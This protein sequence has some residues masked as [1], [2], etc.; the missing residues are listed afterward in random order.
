MISINTVLPFIFISRSIFGHDHSNAEKINANAPCIIGQADSYAV[1]VTLSF[2]EEQMID[3][4]TQ[5]I[6]VPVR[7]EVQNKAGK[8]YCDAEGLWVEYDL[9]TFDT[10][11]YYQDAIDN[12]TALTVEEAQTNWPRNLWNPFTRNTHYYVNG[13]SD[14]LLPPGDY[15]VRAYRGNEYKIAQTSITVAPGLIMSPVTN[16][17]LPIATIKTSA[18]A[19]C[20]CKFLVN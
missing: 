7:V 15:T 2:Y 13:V 14:L 10:G 11:E 18:S 3:G 5:Q 1:A 19:M 20:F 16:R 4:E 17:G 12:P 8:N 6:G 9:R